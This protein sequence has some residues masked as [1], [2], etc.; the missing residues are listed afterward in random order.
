M[1]LNADGSEPEYATWPVARLIRVETG[2]PTAYRLL[3]DTDRLP[4]DSCIEFA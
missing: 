3:D 4:D 2:N 1:P